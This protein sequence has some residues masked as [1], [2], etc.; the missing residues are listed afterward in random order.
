GERGRAA[1]QATESARERADSA[2][3][4]MEEA[5]EQL[6]LFETA[7][8]EFKQRPVAAVRPGSPRMSGQK[9]RIHQT[10]EK[11]ALTQAAKNHWAEWAGPATPFPADT[12]G[13]VSGEYDRGIDCC[14]KCERWW[15]KKY[16]ESCYEKMGKA[17]SKTLTWIRQKL[18]EHM[19]RLNK[20]VGTRATTAEDTS[21][22][23]S[24]YLRRREEIEAAATAEL[25][26]VKAEAV[27]EKQEDQLHAEVAEKALAVY[28]FH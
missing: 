16:P 13:T 28:D 23:A 19:E 22:H 3:G 24:A 17:W 9:V 11:E 15:P 21:R 12:A 26:K 2:R 1:R 18:P 5:R 25:A 14:G 4:D 10:V 8:A 7:L 6:R 20:A 27:R